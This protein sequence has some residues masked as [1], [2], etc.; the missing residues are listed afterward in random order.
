MIHLSK[1]EKILL[2]KLDKKED[3]TTIPFNWPCWCMMNVLKLRKQ[4]TRKNS[5]FAGKN[6]ENEKVPR[7]HQVIIKEILY[8]G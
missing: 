3:V 2:E 6:Q 5:R 7:W 1:E 4:M 8:S